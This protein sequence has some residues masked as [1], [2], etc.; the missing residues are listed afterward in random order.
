MPYKEEHKKMPAFPQCVT[1]NSFQGALLHQAALGKSSV[2]KQC[3]DTLWA[4]PAL[5]PPG[6]RQVLH[7]GDWGWTG[8]TNTEPGA[9]EGS[10]EP[11]PAVPP[12]ACRGVGD[13]PRLERLSGAHNRAR[14]MKTTRQKRHNDKRNWTG[15]LK[16]ARYVLCWAEYIPRHSARG[17]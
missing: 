11:S 9:A 7:E 17:N 10:T 4:E 2:P 8:D 16:R 5:C 13:R 15:H 14:V 12:T 1:C 6:G 3:P